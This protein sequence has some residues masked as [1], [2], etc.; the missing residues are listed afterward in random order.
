MAIAAD[1]R[2]SGHIYNDS[3]VYPMTVQSEE[4]EIS[5]VNSNMETVTLKGN[6]LETSST[7][8]KLA[9]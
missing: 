3:E 1:H 7:I 6:E 5:Y 8:K 9:N 2:R 4:D